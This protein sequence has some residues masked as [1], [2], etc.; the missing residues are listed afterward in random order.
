M[1]TESLTLITPDKKMQGDVATEEVPRFDGL[2]IVVKLLSPN[3]AVDNLP[4][5]TDALFK[6]LGV[7]SWEE[8]IVFSTQD[9]END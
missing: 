7:L 4:A 6:H 1:S 8:L 2:D 5:V 3:A 9:I